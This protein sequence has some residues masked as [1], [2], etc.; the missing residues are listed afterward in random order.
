L[1]DTYNIFA[2]RAHDGGMRFRLAPRIPPPC[3]RLLMVGVF[4]TPAKVY[5]S[6][7]S[8]MPIKKYPLITHHSSLITHHSSL[9]THHYD[10]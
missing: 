5:L 9:I 8:E 2:Y 6:K 7:K 4:Q 1:S 3:T 10:L